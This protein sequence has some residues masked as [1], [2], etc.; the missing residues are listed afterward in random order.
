MECAP[1]IPGP[2]M[3]HDARALLEAYVGLLRKWNAAIN[4][5]SGASLPLIWD[6]HVVDSY[7]IWRSIPEDARLLADLGSGGGFPGVPLAVA[8]HVERRETRVV[9]V[10]SDQRKAAFL[11]EVARVLQL[12]YEVRAER[13]EMT[14]PVLA[15]VVT[16]RALA[17]LHVLIGYAHRHLAPGGRAIFPK[18][19]SAQ[20]EVQSARACWSFDVVAR[21]SE[22]SRD[23][24]LLEVSGIRPAE[25]EHEA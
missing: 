12:E 2:E 9:L 3:P 15:D 7:Q 13:I 18:G 5:V 19:E 4:L 1:R 25:Q 11:R 17:P 8:A 6:R 24:R 14:A 21:P 16:A 22:T 20:S 23:G 10:E